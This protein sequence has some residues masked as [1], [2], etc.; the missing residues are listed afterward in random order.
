MLNLNSRALLP[1]TL[2][3]V[4]SHS[5][6]KQRRPPWSKPSSRDIWGYLPWVNVT[7]DV[8]YSSVN[9]IQ[10]APLYLANETACHE[11]DDETE[12]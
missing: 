7:T 12:R 9:N 8:H 10:T 5:E 11:V 1:S 4:C 2:P 3:L 6:W